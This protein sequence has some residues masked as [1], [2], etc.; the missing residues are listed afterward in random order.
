MRKGFTVLEILLGVAILILVTAIVIISF[1]KMN[2]NKA[3]E[4]SADLIA[5]ILDEARSKSL[6]GEDASVYGVH[7]DA[8]A[9]TLF[10]GRNYSAA[11]P[12]NEVTELNSLTG[13][14][15]IALSGGGSDIVFERMWGNTEQSG[16][17]EIYLINSPEKFKTVSINSAGIV[18]Q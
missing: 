12:D 17:F 5:T 2:E 11:S 13:V 14:R 16:T 10:K 3:L 6:S 7:L 18:E 4:K 1:S 9:A 8:S 15:N